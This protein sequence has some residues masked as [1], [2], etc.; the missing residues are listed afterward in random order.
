M[1]MAPA[2]SADRQYIR[3]R[4]TANQRAFARS[5]RAC[6]DAWQQI[7]R[8]YQ[9]I[10]RLPPIAGGSHDPLREMIRQRLASG[11][12]PRITGRAW[13]STAQGDHVCTCCQQT[14]R[15][16]GPEYEVHDLPDVFAHVAC[17]SHWATESAIAEQR[18][19]AS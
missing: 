9:R 12:L 5:R 13:A 11:T 7:A 6:R 19:L 2:P 18:E 3:S 1:S 8:S 10:H 17:F 16:S 15:T 14:I 4:L